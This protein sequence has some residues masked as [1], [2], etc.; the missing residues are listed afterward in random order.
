[1]TTAPNTPNPPA[2]QAPKPKITVSSAVEGYERC[3]VTWTRKP[4]TVEVEKFT[5][6]DLRSL[7][8]DPTLTVV[9]A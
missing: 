9:D 3:G 4:K 1:M 8:L 7:R 2:E 6:V 5:D